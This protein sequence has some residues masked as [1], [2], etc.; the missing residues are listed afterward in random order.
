MAKEQPEAMG[1]AKT[2]AGWPKQKNTDLGYKK[3]GF[4]P[5]IFFCMID[6]L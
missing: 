6:H 5:G 3:V 2:K 1:V 4:N